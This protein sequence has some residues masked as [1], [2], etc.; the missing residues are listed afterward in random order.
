MLINAS[1]A[2]GLTRGLRHAGRCQSLQQTRRRRRR[3]QRMRPRMRRRT[4]RPCRPRSWSPRRCSCCWPAP[5]SARSSRTPWW[6]L[7]PTSQRCAAAHRCPWCIRCLFN[8]QGIMADAS[9]PVTAVL[10][11]CH[12]NEHPPAA[13]NGIR[14]PTH[15][16]TSQAPTLA[17]LMTH[18]KG[19]GPMQCTGMC[20]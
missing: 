18:E 6:M 8:L 3:T 10:C 14:L 9:H 4:R 2:H 19:C 15:A 12:R 11:D 7:S 20:S 17:P 1:C 5:L 16:C 13:M